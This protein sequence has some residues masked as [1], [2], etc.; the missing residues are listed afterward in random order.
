MYLFFYL[1]QENVSLV[2]L[3]RILAICF[4]IEILYLTVE[5]FLSGFQ[6]KSFQI[7]NECSIL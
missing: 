6:V 1:K 7:M 4:Y 3:L 2:S 5:I